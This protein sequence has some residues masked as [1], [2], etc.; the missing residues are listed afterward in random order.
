MRKEVSISGEGKHDAIA[1][2]ATSK[3]IIEEDK[4]EG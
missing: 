4:I 2:Y 1:K 3:L